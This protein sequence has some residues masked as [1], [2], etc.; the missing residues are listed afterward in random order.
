MPSSAH[1]GDLPEINNLRQPVGEIA[2]IVSELI[3]EGLFEEVI[4]KDVTS[5]N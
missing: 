1:M 3:D 2:A 4:N 5:R